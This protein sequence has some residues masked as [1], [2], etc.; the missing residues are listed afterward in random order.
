MHV[1]G[2]EQQAMVTLHTD[3]NKTGLNLGTKLLNA[4]EDA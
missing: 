3:H 1:C 2:L 4:Y